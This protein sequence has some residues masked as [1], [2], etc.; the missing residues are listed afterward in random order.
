MKDRINSNFYKCSPKCIYFPSE[1]TQVLREYMD[2]CGIK[3]REA[4]YKCNYDG[5]RITTFSKCPFY[6]E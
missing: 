1:P 6:M 3:H 5:H 2:K 4:I